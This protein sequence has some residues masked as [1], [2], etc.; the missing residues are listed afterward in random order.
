MSKKFSDFESNPDTVLTTPA[1]GDLCLIYDQSE[2]LEVNKIKVIS[3]QN[4]VNLAAQAALQALVSGQAAGDLFYA[5]GPASLAR[6]AKGT[7]GQSLKMNGGGTAPVWGSSLS[8]FGS[9]Y[10]SSTDIAT[11]TYADIPDVKIDLTVPCTSTLVAILG[12]HGL[13]YGTSGRLFVRWSIDDTTLNE[14]SLESHSASWSHPVT[15]IGF[16]QSVAV[17]SRV[18]KVQA[19]A[20]AAPNYGYMESITGIVLGFAE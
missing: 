17:G 12:F 7:A 4:L 20:A 19:Y 13:K 14:V 6:L 18:C 11:T 15:V 9:V 1:P 8:C 10:K 2:P 16:K 3:Y 5:S